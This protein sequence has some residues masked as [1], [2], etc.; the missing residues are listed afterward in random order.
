MA[1]ALQK[2]RLAGDALFPSQQVVV[3]GKPGSAKGYSGVFIP[4]IYSCRGL[5]KTGESG[6][7]FFP[8]YAAIGRFIDPAGD[9]VEFIRD[10]HPSDLVVNRVNLQGLIDGIGIDQAWRPGI[11]TVRGSGKFEGGVKP[12][13]TPR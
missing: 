7:L 8:S 3:V 5:V 11:A 6:A 4:K 1:C 9:G 10:G 2:Q 13:I 12:W